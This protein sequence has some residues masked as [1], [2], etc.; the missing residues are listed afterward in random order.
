MKQQSFIQILFVLVMLAGCGQLTNTIY[1]PLMSCMATDFGVQ[2]I[3]MQALMAVYLISYGLSQFIYGPLSDHYG[4]KPIVLIG[5]LIFILGSMVAGTA[6]SF[7]VL[8]LGSFVQ[9]LGTGVGGVMS[10]TVMRDKYSGI[11]LQK[12]NSYISLALILTPLLAPALGGLLGEAFGWHV[13]FWFLSIFGMCVW[14]LVFFMFEETCQYLDKNKISPLA[15][16]KYVFSHYQ[17]N[18]FMV[19]LIAVCAGIAVFEASA[20]VLF[21]E[22][23]HITPKLISILF[24]LPVIGYMVGTWLAGSLVK[25]YTFEFIISFGV[26]M[27]IIGSLSMLITGLLGNVTAAAVIISMGLYFIG[28]GLLFPTVTSAALEPM[29]H[30][31][32]VAG[33]VLGGMQNLGSGLATLVSASIPMH[34]QLPLAAMLCALTLLTVM[35]IRSQLSSTSKHVK[36]S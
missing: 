2:P 36:T 3:S 29:P 35:I 26:L 34:S 15:S 23:M 31:A 16:Y 11:N 30:N 25:G 27:L 1:V 13:I 33:A 8:L 20:G 14:L 17:F 9:G 10:R 22:V 28:A 24:I 21:S 5:L 4:R 7:T 19:T 32:G 12:A 6:H 18:V